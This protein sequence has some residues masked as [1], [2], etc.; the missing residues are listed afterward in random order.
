MPQN[1]LNDLTRNFTTER[2]Y[3]LGDYKNIKFI[4]SVNNIPYPLCFNRDFVTA[5]Q[6]LQLAEIEIIY[7]KYW[8]LIKEVNTIKVEEAMEYL[9]QIRLDTLGQIKFMIEEKEEEE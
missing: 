7:R 5:V 6:S 2:L 4:N 1:N 8:E 3:P 9:E